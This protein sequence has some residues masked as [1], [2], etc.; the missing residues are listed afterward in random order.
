[1]P[2]AAAIE[3]ERQPTHIAEMMERL[4]LEPGASAIARLGLAHTAA[5]RLCR[6]CPF[7]TRCG[8]W[9]ES[10]RGPLAFAPSFCPIA[11]ILFELKFND[12]GALR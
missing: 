6:T 5:L 3:I 7:K 2:A 10:H 12:P 1:M 4:G 8:A 11:D 9:L